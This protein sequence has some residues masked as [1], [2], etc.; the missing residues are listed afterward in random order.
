[1]RAVA[2]ISIELLCKEFAFSVQTNNIDLMM[3]LSYQLKMY[4]Q[5]YKLNSDAKKALHIMSDLE[6]PAYKATNH[7][8][9]ILYLMYHGHL[10]QAGADDMPELIARANE[11]E[12]FFHVH[13]H[14]K[15]LMSPIHA[16]LFLNTHKNHDRAI[17]HIKDMYDNNNRCEA[18]Y[19]SFAYQCDIGTSILDQLENRIHPGLTILK[20]LREDDE[21]IRYELLKQ[22]EALGDMRAVGAIT[23][24]DPLHQAT[25][26][27]E[28]FMIERMRHN[29]GERTS[30]F[31]FH[32]ST[33]TIS[34]QLGR[35]FSP[36]PSPPSPERHF[37]VV[38]EGGASSPASPIGSASS[39]A[40]HHSPPTLGPRTITPYH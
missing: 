29:Y 14:L 35:A 6:R 12:K 34:Q 3:S 18:V 24:I 31:Y 9:K 39:I 16:E 13:P 20:A 40:R 23:L 11:L 21:T 4:V 2:A 1:M 8:M 36:P 25:T 7:Y 10:T 37:G 33:A 28:R 38:A 15:L 17:P 27:R 26:E 22:A 30:A 32:E 5:Q 19:F